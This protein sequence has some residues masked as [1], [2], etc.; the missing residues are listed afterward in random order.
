VAGL[1]T[2]TPAAGFVQPWAAVVIGLLA[3]SVCYYAVQMRIK[4]DWDDALDV[5]GVHGVGGMLG[6]IL[7]GV[8]AVSAING[9]SGLIQGNVHQLLVQLLAV[10]IT[11]VYAYVV[12]LLILK[13]T[14]IFTPVRVTEAEEKVGLD[15][16]LHKE[17]A[18][19]I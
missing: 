7:V 5:W 9:T 16:S 10:V 12:T 2:I 13:V 4:L 11:A 3:G 6:S 14:N 15:T 18:Y 1:A 17:V 8:F 19:H